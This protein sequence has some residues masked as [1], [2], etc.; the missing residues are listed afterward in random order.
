M[1]TDKMGFNCYSFCRI[2]QIKVDD[3]VGKDS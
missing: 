3:V 1:Y 2:S